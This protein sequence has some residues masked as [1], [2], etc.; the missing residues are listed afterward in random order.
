MDATLS[1]PLVG[2][3]IDSR[4]RVLGRIGRGGMGVVYRAE[5]ERLEREVA[6]KVLRSDLAHDADARQRFVRE[7][8]A[9]ARLANPHVVSVL[10]QGTDGEVAYLVMELVPGRT[11]RDAISEQ[12]LLTPGE[13]LAALEDVLDALAEAHRKG[14]VHRDVK[15]ANVLVDDHGRIKVADF[16]LAR[17]AAAATTASGST[18]L[19]GTAEYLA[20][21]RM[22]GIAD[23]RSDVYATG[24]L[25]F[26]MLTGQPPFTGD[27]PANLAY[28]HLYDEVPAPSALVPGL[29]API[30]G[31]VRHATAKD[32]ADRPA[33][34]GEFLVEVRGVRAALGPA[35]LALRAR[36]A[37]GSVG[38]GSTV[39]IPLAADGAPAGP[40]PPAAAGAALAEGIDPADIGYGPGGRTRRG[41]LVA[42]V[43]L[44]LALALAAGVVWFYRAGP[45]AYTD[46]PRP[47]VGRSEADA[48]TA[49]GAA[50]LEV[51]TERAYDETVPE[52]QVISTRPREGEDVR[53][54]GTVTLVVSRG[55]ELFAVPALVRMTR[56]DA[57]KALAEANLA[58]GEVREEWSED[59][60]AGEVVSADPAPDT[61]LR[62]DAPVAL[63]VSRGR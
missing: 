57:E 12:G 9:A 44:V 27:T 61:R 54:S 38:T 34:A 47:L 6:L 36:A 55:P 19:L 8:K 20:P 7:A 28:R 46:T 22:R 51:R 45:G 31:L 52:G 3:R 23:A 37:P 18:D 40:V 39:R 24:V 14:I 25:L 2:R 17:S 42:M 60:P 58:V 62:R 43:A 32:P 26:E 21:E 5:D 13:A 50:G 16:G 59:V 48:R 30:D 10:D 29:P 41:W 11:L 33:D 4:Y 49:L 53:K 63:V 1:D 56:E 15:P 35:D